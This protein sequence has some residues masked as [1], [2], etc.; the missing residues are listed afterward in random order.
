MKNQGYNV[1]IERFVEHY[2]K[3]EI[4]SITLEDIPSHIMERFEGYSK[5]FIIPEEYRKN[6]FDY[7]FLLE[8]KNYMTYIISQE[9]NY[10]EE[11]HV[12]KSIYLFEYNSNS[13]NIGHGEI[14]FGYESEKAFFKDKPFVGF[15]QTE[16][17]FQRQGYGLNRLRI[18]NGLSYMFFNLP[19][20]SDETLTNKAKKVWNKLLDNTEAKKYTLKKIIS[21]K[22]I[23]NERYIFIK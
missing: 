11:N 20:N 8:S 7:A 19:L 6:N 21:G 16:D 2:P 3:G 23:F 22:T 12:E 5:R 10:K 18:M 14:R 13:E 15:T 1:S 9:K 17:K 4:K